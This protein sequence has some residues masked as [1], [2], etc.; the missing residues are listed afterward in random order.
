MKALFFLAL[1]FL[2]MKAFPAGETM[3]PNMGMP[4]PGVG[5]TSGPDWAQDINASFGIVDAHNHCSGSGVQ[6]P[7]CGLNI[8][9]DLTFLG[10]NAT[11][12][13]SVVFSTNSGSPANL[14]IYSNGTDL[15]YNDSSGT[16][17]QITKSH[18]VNVSAGNIQ[19]LPSTPT[20]GAGISWINSGNTFQFLQ[21]S[22]VTGANIDTGS[23]IIRYPGSYPVPSGN[24]IL[25]EAPSS[26]A[27][28]YALK[29]PALPASQKFMTLD[30][31]GNIAAPWAVDNSTLEISSNT[32]QVKALG[33][34]AAQIANGTITG[35]QLSSN[36]NL[37]G[38]QIFIN[39]LT[40]VGSA[41]G[42]S[43]NLMITRGAID[44]V[45]T[46]TS[47]EAFTVSFITTGIFRFNFNATYQDVPVCTA[48]TAAGFVLGAAVNFPTTNAFQTITYDQTTHAQTNQ[49][50][51]FICIGKRP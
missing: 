46:I 34:T 24:Y 16:P 36:I 9:S 8:N 27:S 13:N 51:N 38:T 3:S 1:V 26:L 14:G 33:I 7:P 25:L 17:I 48:T 37:P 10:N 18:G 50:V 39:G 5:V 23:L 20:A 4:I 42:S 31:S 32:L 44:N 19:N 30:A 11:H 41:P 40:I 2:P 22:G 15:F 47:G 29:L 12:V 21:D 35:T 45:G 6:V 43:T 28:Q 49:P